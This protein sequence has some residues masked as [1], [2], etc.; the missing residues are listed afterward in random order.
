MILT[1]TPFLSLIIFTSLLV[2]TEPTFA[3][4]VLYTSRQDDGKF[5]WQPFGVANAATSPSEALGDEKCLQTVCG[6]RLF[7]CVL[8]F[9]CLARGYL[10]RTLRHSSTL[11]SWVHDA[12][13]YLCW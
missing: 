2:L 6:Q 5:P 13:D 3:L 1:Y 9:N 4:P 8:L 12:M 7:D 11:N 10:Q